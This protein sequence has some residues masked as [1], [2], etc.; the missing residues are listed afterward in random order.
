MSRF[1]DCPHLTGIP[2]TVVE[3]RTH[4]DVREELVP[5]CSKEH[6]LTLLIAQD[7]NCHL[8]TVRDIVKASLEHDVKYSYMF[9]IYVYVTSKAR[10]KGKPLI[11]FKLL[12]FSNKLTHIHMFYYKYTLHL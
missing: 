6:G 2:S 10:M 12:Y 8:Q 9:Y 1:L 11:F 7:R 5:T 4:E 3:A